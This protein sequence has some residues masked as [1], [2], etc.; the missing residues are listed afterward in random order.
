LTR[1]EA[2]KVEVKEARDSVEVTEK[3]KISSEMAWDIYHILVER[4]GAPDGMFNYDTF[5]H[6]TTGSSEILEYRF[7][8]HLGMGGKVRVNSERWK[9]DCYEEDL[10]DLRR[11]II[12]NTNRDL[13]ALKAQYEEE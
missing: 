9:V 8:G 12:A 1:S 13:A 4:A 10:N 11:T 6:S 3:M 7:I 2:S 5:I